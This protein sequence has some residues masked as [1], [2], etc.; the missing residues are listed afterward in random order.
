MVRK[1]AK[2]L[3]L[4]MPIVQKTPNIFRQ[5]FT[6]GRNVKIFIVSIS[7]ASH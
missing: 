1:L 6:T 4:T 3:F 5:G 7:I 2:I